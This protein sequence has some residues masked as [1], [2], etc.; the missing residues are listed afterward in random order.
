MKTRE[1]GPERHHV[2][3]ILTF[4]EEALSGERV[5]PAYERSEPL[6]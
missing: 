4:G 5:D 1:R 3:G 6:G 2:I